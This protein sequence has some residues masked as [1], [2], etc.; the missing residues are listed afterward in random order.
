MKVIVWAVFAVLAAGWT[1]F[2][3]LSISVT[4]WLLGM[5]ASGQ[6]N[7][8]A[9][10]AGQWPV[11]GWAAVWV[12]PA[13]VQSLQAAWLGLVQWLS[14][15]LPST[16]SLMDWVAPL[17]WTGWALGMLCLVVPAVALHWL[18]GRLGTPSLPQR[19]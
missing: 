8:L 14:Q 7:E 9:T 15:V 16:T 17:M 4:R 5:G 2:V 18:A 6:A 10:A 11:P 1:G 12:D 19:A 3:A 13:W